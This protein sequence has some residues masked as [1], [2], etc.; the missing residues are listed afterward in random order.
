MTMNTKTIAVLGAGNIGT[1]MARGLMRGGADVR[2]YNRGEKR[3]KTFAEANPGAYCTTDISDA[4]SGAFMVLIC[5]EGHAAPD[6]LRTVA[7]LIP[8]GNVL[9]GS[10]AAATTLAQMMEFCPGARAYF[11]LLPNIAATLGASANLL[12][13]CGLTTQEEKALAG[14]FCHTGSTTIVEERLFPAAMA[15][16]SCG[17]AFALRYLRA[18][19]LAGVQAGLSASDSQQLTAAVFT[20]VAALLAGGEHPDALVD[21]VCTPGG[22]TIRGV[23]AMERGGFT[24]AVIEGILATLSK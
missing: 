12:C 5:V 9:I 4:L 14:S 21:R 24:S 6:V 15:L 1:A 10:C 13:S 11:R 2:V 8:V 3:L 7:S 17:I 18:T 20:G 19:M 16:S 23:N 22:V